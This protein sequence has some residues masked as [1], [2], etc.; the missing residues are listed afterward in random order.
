MHDGTL[1]RTSILLTGQFP[2]TSPRHYDTVAFFER[3]PFPVK[4]TVR[5]G[6]TVAVTVLLQ[7]VIQTALVSL[8][9]WIAS[10]PIGIWVAPLLDRGELAML[11][12]SIGVVWAI[13]LLA[14]QCR[15]TV[16]Q[17]NRG[18]RQSKFDGALAPFSAPWD[19]L[20]EGPGWWGLV[21]WGAREL[22]AEYLGGGGETEVSKDLS[23]AR[24]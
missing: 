17:A 12:V 15:N 24:C 1:R 3:L 4:R 14:K 18:T 2:A 9:A 8:A 5:L 10:W 13:C 11:S 21:S 16:G 22:S 6:P 7:L 19:T 20:Q 23:L